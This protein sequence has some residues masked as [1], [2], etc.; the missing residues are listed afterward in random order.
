LQAHDLM[1]KNLKHLFDYRAAVYD[2]KLL[3]SLSAVDNENYYESVN[4]LFIDPLVNYQVERILVTESVDLPD[5]FVLLGENSVFVKSV[6]GSYI[7]QANNIIKPDDL[8]GKSIVVLIEH[9]KQHDVTSFLETIYG[10]FPKHHFFIL[11]LTPFVLL[12]AFFTN[13]FN[14]RLIFNDEVHTFIFI[15]IVFC[16]TYLLDYLAKVW[17]KTY[18]LNDLEEDSKK[19]ERYFL[20]LLPFL[21]QRNIITK[22][23]TIESS[24]KVVWEA[25]SAIL[26]DGVVFILLI[27]VLFYMVG[28]SVLA[29]LLFY[30]AIV[31]MSIYIRYKNYKMYI[32][33]EA[34]QQE[35]LIE[36]ISYYQN[37]KQFLYLDPS[38]Y[39]SQFERVCK[40][41][42]DMDKSITL[43]NFKW[44]EFVK[45]SSFAATI[46]LFLVIFFKV[47]DDTAIF[48]ILIALLI[49]NSRVS[50]A[51]V[52]FVT[53]G[54]HLLSSS[55]HIRKSAEGLFENIDT[56]VFSKGFLPDR[57]DK[58]GLVD[59][60]ITINE[61]SLLRPSNIDFHRG[62]VYGIS[63]DVG[64]GK[65]TFLKCL[66]RSFS[67]FSGDIIFN[68]QYKIEDIDTSFFYKK[69]A[70]LDLSSDFVS[71][72]LYY[73]FSIRGHRNN[74]YIITVVKNIMKGEL[75]DYE[76][77]FQKDIFSIHM[78]TGQR[79]KLLIAMTL[80]PLKDIYVFDEVFSNMTQS[81]LASL[82]YEIKKQVD[83]PIIFIVSHDRNVL[84]ISDV[85]F[86]IRDKELL[87]SKSSV[88]RV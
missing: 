62:V 68:E 85:V 52:S 74:D 27:S 33:N 72:S 61:R 57:I 26:V 87:K 43:F 14:T 65:S 21:N 60:A 11:L 83:Q 29:L 34:V 67:E 63:G 37:N 53:R 2:V 7:T 19:I 46:V 64:A 55:Y 8:E 86:E 22:I 10:F 84:A 81:D 78:S 51:A 80:S 35:L 45:A 17:I 31:F 25:L 49:I 6:E 20:L 47:K 82:I 9:P 79:R 76:F 58:I 39:L 42:L 28:A 30:V 59:F 75:I 69:V 48:N 13:L 5:S 56:T 18:T 88:I 3:D 24:K 77:V 1:K 66:T 38:F 50:S 73:N 4:Q 12:P 36:R 41:V 71:G 54:F 40:K 23:R 16:S 70:Y 32:E 15:A 44:D